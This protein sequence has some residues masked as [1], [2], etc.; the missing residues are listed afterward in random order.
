VASGPDQPP[1]GP[2]RL[3]GSLARHRWVAAAGMTA[4]IAAVAG[5]GLALALHDSSPGPPKECGL[6][7][8]AAALPASVQTSGDGAASAPAA[9]VPTAAQRATT[10]PGP[11]G[12]SGPARSPRSP[13]ASAPAPGTAPPETAPP[14]TA[15][16]Q[17]AAP[18]ERPASAEPVSLPEPRASCTTVIAFTARGTLSTPVRCTFSAAVRQLRTRDGS[19]HPASWAAGQDGDR[20]GGQLRPGRT[21]RHGWQA[22]WLSDWLSRGW[23]GGRT[24]GAGWSGGGWS[25]GGW[26]GGG[27][28]GQHGGGPGGW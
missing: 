3:A 8:C 11:S 4:A 17:A 6:V 18:A 16:P 19:G 21:S 24:P 2:P 7:P 14:E 22:S 28:W 23:S 27:Q 9:A 20:A 1:A 12:P 13:G 26:S 25:G 15:P 5:G 10:P